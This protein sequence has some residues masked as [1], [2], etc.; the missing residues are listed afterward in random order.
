MAETEPFPTA[1]AQ[2][3]RNLYVFASGELDASERERSELRRRL[4]LLDRRIKSFKE[5]KEVAESAVCR[6]CGGHGKIRNFLSHDEVEIVT[7]YSCGG[8][9]LLRATVAKK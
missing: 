5:I 9:G 3:L 1:E 7:C 6:H 8:S 2:R 4:D